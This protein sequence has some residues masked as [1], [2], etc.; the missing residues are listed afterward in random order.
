MLRAGIRFQRRT[1]APVLRGPHDVRSAIPTI[2]SSIYCY[3]RNLVDAHH[4]HRIRGVGQ[5]LPATGT[6]VCG[7]S[8]GSSDE[9]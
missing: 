9:T 1:D 6:V 4:A 5:F 7:N 3:L 2:H 8:T